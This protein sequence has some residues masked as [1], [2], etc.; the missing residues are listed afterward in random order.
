MWFTSSVV[1]MSTNAHHRITLA[2]VALSLISLGVGRVL[3][4]HFGLSG[5]ALALL[6]IDIPM[7][8]LVLK[9]SL[10]QL[11]ERLGDFIRAILIFHLSFRSVKLP[12]HS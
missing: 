7:T 11:H 9:T 8:Y 2:F 3:L 10:R 5:T 6:L 4:A 1:P 12:E